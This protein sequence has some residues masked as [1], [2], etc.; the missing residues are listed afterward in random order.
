MKR[1]CAW[2]LPV[3]LC[4][5]AAGLGGVAHA[6]TV[7]CG[8][9]ITQDTV[10]DA[11]VGPC[12]GTGIVV[13]GA[14][15]TLD[16]GGHTVFGAPST[17]AS[18]ILIQ[19]FS[20]GNASVGVHV[21]NG[22]ITRFRVGVSISRSSGNTLER[23]SVRDN[24]CHGIEL[25]GV[26]VGPVGP[27]GYNIVRG[28][29]IKSNGCAGLHLFQYAVN[30]T[31]EWNEIAEN[32]GSGIDIAATGTNNRPN[33]NIVQHNAVHGNGGDGVTEGGSRNRFLGNV[34]RENA[35]NGVHILSLLPFPEG[36]R[37]EGNQILGNGHN[38]VLIEYGFQHQV[39]SNVVTGNGLTS[40]PGS[41]PGFDLA[42]EDACG[43]NTW[44]GNTFVTRNQPCLM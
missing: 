34:F 36:S 18:G 38:G 21:R 19:P 44:L 11:D 28:N 32:L 33:S 29:I 7:A 22:T 20:G 26:A 31:V 40:Q 23:L 5:G 13:G 43:S 8:E 30:N 42:D 25:Q 6:A 41:A 2:L 24:S 9:V 17:S 35:L 37:V 39:V 14:N 10:L 3:T 4:F 1:L 27:A 12:P 15:V 16:L